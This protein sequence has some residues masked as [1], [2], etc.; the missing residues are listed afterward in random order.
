MSEPL[1]I[2]LIEDRATDADLI[3]AELRAV[4]RPRVETEHRTSLGAGLKR[5]DDGGVDLVLLDFS[6]PDSEGLGTYHRVR[7]AHPE[8]PVIVLTGLDDDGVAAAAVGDGAQD[9]LVKREMDHRVLARAI[10]YALGRHRA[11]EA[12]RRSEE[13]YALAVRGANDGLWDWD[14][15]AG[16][17]YLSPRWKQMLGYRPDEL[18]DRQD[19]WFGCVH[20]D[21]V[22]E[23]RSALEVHFA[24]AGDRFER[25]HRMRRRD[26][27]D[28]WVLTRGVVV[29]DPAGRVTRMAGSMTDV[30][31]R[32]R[33]EA[34][35]VHDAFHDALTG[36]ANR[37]LFV[38]RMAVAQ[39]ASLRRSGDRF[40]VLFL[41]LDRFKNVNDSLGHVVGDRLLQAI[42]ARLLDLVR[43][44]DTVARLGGDEFA[45]LVNRIADPSD[46]IRVAERVQDV[47][48]EPFQT[49][50]HEVFVTASIGIAY[51]GGDDSLSPESLLRDADIAM[52]RAKAAGRAQYVVFDDEMH[53]SAVRLLRLE[54]ELRRAVDTEAFVM[55]YQPIV[56]LATHE[57]VGFEALVR[58]NHPERGLVPPAVFIGVAEETGLIVRLGWWVLEQACRQTVDWQRRHPS[59]PP[60]FSS[61]NFSGKLFVQPDVV[62]RV[63]AILD[64]TGLPATSLR[65]EITENVVL[66]HGDRA[67]TRLDEL[68]SLG[69]QLSVDDFGT[70]Y[71]SLSYL[72]RF[73]YDSL[74]IDRS[75]VARIG[76]PNGESQAIVESILALAD[77]L[78]I[79]VIAE[80]VETAEQA[81][82]L[83]NL[84][85]PH[86]QGFWFARPVDADRAEALLR[87]GLPS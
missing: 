71:S 6:L 25:E 57:I 32:K 22:G 68:R 44:G 35:L 11:D 78:G 82:W 47:L 74:K 86:G 14:V 67:V 46:P 85:C 16:R 9:Y 8:V 76:S 49:A 36:L 37:A 1:R 38:D 58:W 5:L 87:T 39:A 60:L 52:Y 12:L 30:D 66:D 56:D 54:T 83:R 72:Q 21:D 3:R 26:G 41:D 17:I 69:V 34:K 19:S 15:A 64:D 7:D 51:G 2:L 4:R 80:G 10:R 84:R 18:D 48:A 20:P 53:R 29:R 63:T 23:L 65:L 81:A 45:V 75:F 62:E 40:A 28:V 31:A 13:R 79:G 33:A 50:G 55:H 70:G 43:P 77:S 42:A 24:G 61:V 27:G 59:T 73:H